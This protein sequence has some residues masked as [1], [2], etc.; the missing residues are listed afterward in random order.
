ML[1]FLPHPRSAWH[2]CHSRDPAAGR[3]QLD[4]KLLKR[5]RILALSLPLE[6]P[7][8]RLKNLAFSPM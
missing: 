5:K 4:N 1:K 6:N 3:A 8:K 2:K 7:S